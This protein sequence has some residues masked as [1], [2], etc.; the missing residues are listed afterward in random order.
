MS[1][2]SNK[3][4]LNQKIKKIFAAEVNQN[5]EEGVWLS[6]L[7]REGEYGMAKSTISSILTNKDAIKAT[8]VATE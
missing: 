2:M 1:Q 7:S 8:D 6:D 4:D 5:T 3:S